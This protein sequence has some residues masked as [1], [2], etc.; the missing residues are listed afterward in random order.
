MEQ[1]NGIQLTQQAI[2][3]ARELNNSGNFIRVAFAGGCGAFG[4][5]ISQTRRSYPG[6]EVGY[7]SSQISVLLDR[8]A[9]SELAG[10]TL[11]YEPEEGFV[12]DHPLTGRTC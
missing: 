7:A 10:S 9:A 5:R 3:Q 8:R 11:D 1:Q 12:L 4:H 6:D 2:D